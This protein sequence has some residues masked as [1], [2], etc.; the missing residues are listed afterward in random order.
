MAI[1]GYKYD[2]SDVMVGVNHVT[3]EGGDIKAKGRYVYFNNLGGENYSVYTLDGK[4][5]KSGKLDAPVYAVGLDAGVYI[6]KA[7]KKA[8]K[9]IVK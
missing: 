9:V 7:G 3:A 8:V 4:L 1:N 6:A 5:V 2:L